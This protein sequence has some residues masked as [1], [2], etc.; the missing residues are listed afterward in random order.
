[1]KTKTIAILTSILASALSFGAG[2]GW[3]TNFEEAKKKAAS[4]KKDLI[5]DF[6]GSDWCPPCKDL[7]KR[8]LSQ[9]EF[10]DGAS[11]N[12][13]L[14]ELDFPRDKTKVTPEIAE[15]NSK[16]Q[17][18][19]SITGYPTILL[20]D[21]E[22][23]PYAK[24]GHRRGTPAEYLSH[25]TEIQKKKVSRDQA[26]AESEKLEGVEKSKVLAA[27]LEGMPEQFAPFYTNFAEIIIKNDPEDTTQFLK[28]KQ[29]KEAAEK[30]QKDFETLINEK[31]T[32]AIETNK[33]DLALKL[34]DTFINDRKPTGETKQNMVIAKWGIYNHLKDI[35]GIEKTVNEAI[36]IAPESRLAKN[37]E[38]YKANQLK[39]MKEKAAK[40][41]DAAKKALEAEEKA[42]K[43]AEAR[44]EAAKKALL[45]SH[46]AKEGAAK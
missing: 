32:K 10:I 42:A 27:L 18:L 28:K 25:L 4:E 9:K 7:T 33:T 40:K 16:L 5:L 29:E 1:M 15:Q 46:K 8:I 44:N 12:Y 37:L 6:T 45:E 38:Q 19:Y 35:E 3:L 43:E 23:R 20:T 13:I 21:A 39:Q 36:A 14:V 17:E 11:K 2:E 24:T 26:I 31:V 34:I 22:G 41:E 30:L